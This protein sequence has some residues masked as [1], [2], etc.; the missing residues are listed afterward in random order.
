M[1]YVDFQA[2]KRNVGMLQILEHYGILAR[3]HRSVGA[4]RGPCPIHQGHNKTQFRVSLTKNCWNCFGDCQGGGGVI[5]FVAKMERTDPRQ[6]ALLI[7]G[8]FDVARLPKLAPRAHDLA[9]REP[10]KNPPLKFVL[11]PLDHRHPYLKA[12]GLSAE[13]TRTFGVGYCSMGTMAGRIVIPIHSE[14]GQLVAYVG[15]WPGLPPQERPKYKLPR[16][17]GK[18][19]E[20]F[21]LHRAARQ[22]KAL[23]LVVVE[24]FFDCI[25]LWQNGI[26]RVVAIMGS[27]LSAIQAN[28]ILKQL[29]QKRLVILMFDEDNA[30]RI[31]REKAAHILKRSAHVKV[32]RFSREGLQPEDLR[33]QELQEILSPYR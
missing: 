17:F 24:G 1:N 29:G 25:K 30:G 3:F 2:I 7:R 26:R 6:A 13:S 28:L 11:S 23:P 33:A 31:G 18:S 8:W 32:V 9:S 14:S 27:S 12:R 15:R 4:L 20:V 16:G 10:R 5:D 22:P 19:L 21:N